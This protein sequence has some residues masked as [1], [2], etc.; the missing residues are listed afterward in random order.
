MITYQIETIDDVQEEITP[1]LH[2]HYLEIT[3]DKAIKPLDVDWDRYR[4]M[5]EAGALRI[6][7]ARD[8][9]DI[10][11]QPLGA[12]RIHK[13]HDTEKGYRGRLVGYFCS[14][15]IKHVHYQQTT[16][17]INDVLYVDPVH[18]RG[19]VGYKL[20][21]RAAEDLKNLGADILIIHMKVDYPFRNLLIR[22]GYTL[23]EE[24][25]EKVL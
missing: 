6:M 16:M 11:A 12:V 3:T 5:E 15:V 8:V 14:F 19:M 20:I 1:L 24:N 18:R 7:T 21:K 22:Q 13:S 17:A 10:L 2:T 9:K 23:T 4:D 25:W